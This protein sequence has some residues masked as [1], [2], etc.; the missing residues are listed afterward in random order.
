MDYQ[1]GEKLYEKSSNETNYKINFNSSHNA[2][3]SK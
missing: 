1:K 2:N 3:A